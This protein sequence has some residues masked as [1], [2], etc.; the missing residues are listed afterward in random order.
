V[1]SLSQNID[2]QAQM[3]GEDS[4]AYIAYQMYRDAGI[5][6]TVTKSY[7]DY[8]DIK[9][10]DRP[11]EDDKVRSASRRYRAW[12]VDFCWDDRVSDWDKGHQQRVQD[13]L[14]K[15]DAEKYIATVK[16]VREQL[17]KLAATNLSQAM[18]DAEIDRNLS[19]RIAQ[20]LSKDYRSLSAEDKEKQKISSAGFSVEQRE[21]M[22]LYIRM[23][24]RTRA[25]IDSIDKITARMF[26][27][28]GLVKVVEDLKARSAESENS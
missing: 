22:S 13:M 25:T 27:A 28:L 11:K 2:L 26:N 12:V 21:L 10:P 18:I 7:N 14:L 1:T 8:Q 6:R 20:G 16:S 19:A 3:G 5:S 15:E 24:P 9:N 17:E 4:D 23:A